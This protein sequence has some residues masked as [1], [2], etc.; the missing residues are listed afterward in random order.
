M[1]LTFSGN[2]LG[3]NAWTRFGGDIRV[4]LADASE[5]S[6]ATHAT[7]IPGRSFQD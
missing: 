3:V 2:R 6:R 4:E 7:P 1:L 5:E